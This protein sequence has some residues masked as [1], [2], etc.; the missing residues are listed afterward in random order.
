M[1]STI[2]A[3]R[4]MT[5]A[6]APAALSVAVAEEFLLLD[7]VSGRNAA[8]RERAGTGWCAD[9]RQIRAGLG[10]LREAAA[11][12][13]E[14]SGVR[15][16]AIGATPVGETGP[17]GTVCGLHVSVEA[18]DREI[19]AQ[20]PGHLRVWLPVIRALAVNSPL[21]GGADTGHSSWRSVQT[22]HGSGLTTDG[23]VVTVGVADVCTDL[24]DAVLVTALIRAAVATTV[25]DILDRRP[26]PEVPD[27]AVAA[28][29]RGAARDGLAGELLDL[30]L[31]RARPAWEL[32]DEFFATVSPALLFSGDLDLV[33]GGLARLRHTGDG[34]ARQRRILTGTGDVRAVLAA[35]AAWTRT[36]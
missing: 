25:S 21:F 7:P 24:D 15:L 28:A 2:T 11:E 3:G 33:V 8:P 35:L 12:A 10:G 17:A 9:L 6:T 23:R 31:D 34:A 30:R 27:E 26:A 20:V 22:R 19:A 4:V 32:V 18:P 5:G 13:A 36:F 14:A 16:V 1:T 29:H